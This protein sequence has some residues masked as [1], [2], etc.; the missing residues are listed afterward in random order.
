MSVAWAG[1]ME[2]NSNQL[3]ILLQ[4]STPGVGH[5]DSTT[6]LPVTDYP[7][8]D[9]KIEIS[10]DSV[11]FKRSINSA[12]YVT[13]AEINSDG[14]GLLA[15]G[16]VSWDTAG[17]ITLDASKLVLNN[18]LNIRRTTLGTE[19]INITDNNTFN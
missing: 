13:T 10:P 5:I 7:L 2:I 12:A 11:L 17:N 3:C 16:T 9:R 18:G 6:N 15:S 4:K 1:D 14:S 19:V 8:T